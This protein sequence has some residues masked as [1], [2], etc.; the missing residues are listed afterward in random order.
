MYHAVLADASFFEFL[1]RIDADLAEEARARACPACGARL[2]RAR[3]PRKPRGVPQAAEG[4][5]ERRESFCCCRE[6]CRQ[7]ATPPSVRFLGRKV[8]AAVVVVLGTAMMHGLT[9]WRAERLERELDVSR[10]TLER[11][12][13]WWREVFCGSRFWRAARARLSPPVEEG[14][15]PGSLLARFGGGL[16]ERILGL[17]RFLGPVTTSSARAL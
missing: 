14:E 16:R 1:A 11:W 7:R 5:W 8:Y 10:R 9:D 4:A 17:L 13:V 12:R 3:Y 15:L 2:D 6:G